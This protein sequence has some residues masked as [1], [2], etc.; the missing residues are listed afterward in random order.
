M[1]DRAKALKDAE[2]R[3]ETDPTCSDETTSTS[4]FDTDDDD[5][6]N[7]VVDRKQVASTADVATASSTSRHEYR[8]DS[9]SISSSPGKP[10]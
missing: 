7:D 9:L 4:T 1:T 8:S 10:Y 3:L 5:N 6:V 2:R